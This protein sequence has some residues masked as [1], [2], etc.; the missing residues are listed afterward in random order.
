MLYYITAIN[1]KL[2]QGYSQTKRGTYNRHL[3]KITSLPERLFQPI[4]SILWHEYFL[5]K[6]L[7]L[8]FFRKEGRGWEQADVQTVWKCYQNFRITNIYKKKKALN[9]IAKSQLFYCTIITNIKHLYNQMFPAVPTNQN[10]S[11]V[12]GGGWRKGTGTQAEN[13][14]CKIMIVK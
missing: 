1:I 9:F 8:F 10:A 13:E 2:E 11:M 7:F 6:Q 12:G 3:L 4:W 14:I 5:F